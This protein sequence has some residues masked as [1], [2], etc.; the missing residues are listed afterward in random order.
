MVSPRD[1]IPPG[2]EAHQRAILDTAMT[3]VS[4]LRAPGGDYD[5]ATGE[6]QPGALLAS[7]ID[8]R[9]HGLAATSGGAPSGRVEDEHTVEVIVPMEQLP[10]LNITREGPIIVVTAYK[11]GHLG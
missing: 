7:N 5:F 11:Q 10:P 1:M 2:W 6:Q 8:C 4:E 3:A 9:V